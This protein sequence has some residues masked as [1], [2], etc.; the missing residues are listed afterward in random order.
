MLTSE[1]S[2]FERLFLDHLRNRHKHILD[3]V[4]KEGSL[5]QKTES[6][7]RAIIEE[8]IPSSGLSTKDK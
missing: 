7:L 1:I 8:F 4:R 6:E 2:K 5:S 3:T